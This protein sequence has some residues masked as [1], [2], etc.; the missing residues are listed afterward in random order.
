[1]LGAAQC[2]PPNHIA[3]VHGCE[4]CSGGGDNDG[5]YEE[6]KEENH[7]SDDHLDQAR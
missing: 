3:S 6:P 5:V 2:L 7:K 1:M 4:N